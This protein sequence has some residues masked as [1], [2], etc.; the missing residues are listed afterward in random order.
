MK[1]S[2]L[3]HLRKRLVVPGPVAVALAVI[4][5]AAFFIERGL[6]SNA[7]THL[8]LTVSILDRGTLNIDPF[9]LDT[10]DL[11]GANGHFYADKAPGLSLLALPFYAIIKLLLAHGQ[12]YLPLLQDSS[13]TADW[14][15]YILAVIFDAVPTGIIAALLYRFMARMGVSRGWCAALGLTYGLGTIA[16]PYA[17]VFFS[18]QFTAA[19]CFGAFY[20]LYRLRKG[21]LDDRFAVLV[22]L[23]L[24]Y[25]LISE[26]PTALIVA[27]LGVYLVTTPG[28]TRE[29]LVRLLAYSGVAMVPSFVIEAVYNTLAFGSPLALGYNHLAGPEI[30]QK[31]Q[32]QGLFGVTYPHL[33]AI[34]GTTFSPYRG[35]FLLSPVL[36]LAI[37]GCVKLV[38]RFGWRAEGWL[39]AA[40]GISYFFFNFSYF[41]WDGGAS[42]GPRQILP[43]LPFLII[44]IGELVRPVAAHAAR[45]A[46]AWLAAV[47]IIVVEL[48]A[49]VHPIFNTGYYWPITQIV[50]PR[51]AGLPMDKTR[52]WPPNL[53]AAMW[54]QFPFFLGARLDYNWA[55]L[56]DLPGMTQ[57]YALGALVA[58]I[59]LWATLRVEL[60]PR[61]Q[62][63]L[64]RIGE[65]VRGR[66]QHVLAGLR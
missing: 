1:E 24:G 39:C 52:M 57:L 9:H 2:R 32:A 19:L 40:I 54:H 58:I 47:S 62:P 53:L 21:E 59:L 27:A 17:S 65:R 5:V 43:C 61:V 16:R 12:P 23:L 22:G 29:R 7:G 60:F 36:L 14:E 50:L 34:W 42:M 6:Q 66:C 49:A 18:H 10:V 46:T 13:P 33:D 8:Y 48:C 26:Y 11:A 64:S 4:V 38:Q 51:L 31:G 56:P 28:I 45:T 25:S 41:A 63:H 55:Q 35:I 30:F 44:P 37:P 15:R 3:A 20:L